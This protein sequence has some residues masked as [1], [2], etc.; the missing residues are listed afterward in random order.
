MSIKIMKNE[1]K[2][3]EAVY[4]TK[5]SRRA[6]M[7]IARDTCYDDGGAHYPMFLR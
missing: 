3:N 5:R 7:Q 1:Y 6:I 4:G 2:D